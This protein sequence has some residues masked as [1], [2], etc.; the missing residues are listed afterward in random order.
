MLSSWPW[1]EDRWAADPAQDSAQYDSMAPPPPPLKDETDEV[2]EGDISWDDFDGAL[3]ASLPAQFRMPKI[4]RYTGIGMPLSQTFQMLMEGGLL[5]H[6]A[7]RPVPQPVPPR[8]RMDLHYQGL[9][10]LGQPS[11]TTNPLPTHSMHAVPPSPG[12][13]HH[14][15]FVEDDNIHMMSWDDGLLEPIVLDDGYEVDTL[16]DDDM[17]GRDVQIVTRSGRV[18]QP[19]PLV[20]RPFDGAVSHEEVRREDDEILRQLQSTQACISIWS[21]LASSSTHRDALIRALSQIRMETTTTPKRLIH[22]MMADGAICHRVSSVLLDNGSALNVYLLATAITLGYAPSDSGPSTQTVKAYDSTKME[23]MDTLMIKLLIGL[24]TFPILFQYG[25]TRHDEGMPFMP[26]LGL[27]RRQHGPMEFVA[28]VDHDTPF[29]LRFVPTEAD[30]RMSL[31]DYFATGPEV[32]PHMGDSSTMTDLE[33]MDELHHQFHHLQLGNETSGAPVLVMI[34]S[35]SPGQAS[36]LS[37]SFPDE[38]TDY[39][40]DFEPTRVTDGVVPLYGYRD[41]MDMSMIRLSRWLS[42][43]LL[44]LSICSDICYRDERD[45]LIHLLRSYLDVFAWSYEDMSGLDPSIVKEEIQKQLSV[46]FI[47]VVE[48]PKWLAN[49]VP[50]PK[51]DGKVRV[52][53]DFRDLNKVSPKDDFPLPHID[54]LVDKYCRAFD[55]VLH[56]WILGYNQ[57][58][59]ALEDMEKTTFITEWGADHLATLERFFERIRKFRSRLNPKK[60]TFGVTSRKLL[61]HMVSDQGIEVDPD[62]IKAILDMP[63][64]RTEKEINGFLGSQTSAKA[65]EDE[66][67]EFLSLGVK[68]VRK[69]QPTVWNDDYQIAFEK[70]KEYLLSPPVLVPPMPRHPLLLY[71]SL[72]NMDLGCMLAR[73]DDSGKKRAI[74]YLSKRMLEYDMRYVMIEHLCLVSVE[75]SIKG[76]IVVDHLASLPIS[77]D[78]PVDDNFPDEEF[79]AMTNLSGWRMHFDG[80][81]N[82]SRFGIGVLLISSQGDHIPRS[83]RLAFS[84][85]HPA[86]NNIV[87]YEACILGLETALELEIRQME[88]CTRLLLSDWRDKGRDDLPWYH[89]IYQLLRSG[90]YPEAATGKYWRAMRQLV[91][92]GVCGPHMGGHMLARKIMRTNYFWLT[93]KIDCYQ[94][95]QRCPECQIHGDLIHAPPLELHALTSPWSFSVLVETEMG[96]LRV[97]L[98]QQ[99]SEIEWAEVRFDQLNLL[100][101]ERLR[102]ADH[103][104]AY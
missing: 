98:E 91:H 12:G 33:R 80:A 32:H 50:V 45:R 83:V 99:I 3:V 96:S 81:A 88:V 16:D 47:S 86:M 82:H 65:T 19:P 95:V 62:K 26:S 23:V 14:I 49:V 17:E 59:M 66:W 70:I 89:D 64:P 93:M 18:T 44:H 31:A 75:K 8:F 77:K 9:V 52:C 2:S 92:E 28:T 5:T 72:S 15:D 25:G 1:P 103:V 30:Y 97:A 54:L 84:D 42:L 4:E 94:F 104:Q 41:E 67:L 100:D 73:L 76:S 57:I 21:L 39:G 53:V 20:A 11:V 69:N 46:W 6:L 55:V 102:A 63:V 85:Q 90:T 61:G 101:E 87:E 68:K 36:F 37:L 34:A 38:T 27:G 40:V 10:N 29:G 35:S 74:Y 22:M 51:K 58:L 79:I 13:I 56:G 43:S 7:P 24:A 71:L 78:R 60:C 48:Y